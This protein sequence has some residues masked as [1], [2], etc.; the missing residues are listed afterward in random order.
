MGLLEDQAGQPHVHTGFHRCE[1]TDY[2]I[3]FT[4]YSPSD[5]RPVDTAVVISHGF[6][7]SRNYHAGF[8]IRLATLGCV[9]LTWDLQWRAAGYKC[10]ANAAHLLQLCDGL[11]AG[12]LGS[13]HRPRR[14]V[15]VGFSAGGAVALAAANHL[16]EYLELA[17][18]LLLDAVPT[19]TE[20]QC[21]EVPVLS[22]RSPPCAWNSSGSIRAITPDARDVVLLSAKHADFEWPA[23]YSVETK[24][25]LWERAIGIRA[26][27]NEAR[28][29]AH[30]LSCEFCMERL[31]LSSKGVEESL[32]VL[33]RD[34]LVNY[35]VSFSPRHTTQTNDNLGAAGEDC[36]LGAPDEGWR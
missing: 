32:R 29:A 26:A 17:G 8:A 15:L 33:S 21:P 3:P 30:H 31:G 5:G 10:T 7:R 13:E 19:S 24:P 25:R 2:R 22:I 9:A 6:V 16:T 20:L 1:R 18:V 27:D 28:E 12:Q 23:A 36:Y 11:A 4:L 14:L 34:R 35:K